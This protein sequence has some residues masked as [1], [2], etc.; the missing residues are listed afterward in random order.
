MKHIGIILSAFYVFLSGVSAY[1]YPP[2]FIP[3]TAG[4]LGAGGYE[5]VKTLGLIK[6]E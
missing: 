3:M 5:V 6:H 1:F 4:Y 2:L